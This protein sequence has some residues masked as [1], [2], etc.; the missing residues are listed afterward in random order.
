MRR[1]LIQNEMALPS[2]QNVVEGKMRPISIATLSIL[3][4]LGNPLVSLIVGVSDGS[5]KFTD[6]VEN[7]LELFYIHSV[8]DEELYNIVDRLFDAPDEIKKN[9]IIWGCDMNINDIAKNLNELLHQQDIIQGS[10]VETV[11]KRASKGSKKA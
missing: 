9:A 11:K 8:D 10:M 3:E 5:V 1:E 7:L 2:R 6:S 4:R